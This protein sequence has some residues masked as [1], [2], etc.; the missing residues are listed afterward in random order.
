MKYEKSYLKSLSYKGFTWSCMSD[1]G[2]YIFSKRIDNYKSVNYGKY[3][4]VAVNEDDIEDGSYKAMI[5]D[6][7]TRTFKL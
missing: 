1:E 3:Q 6:G 4:V 2:F 7:I 5:N